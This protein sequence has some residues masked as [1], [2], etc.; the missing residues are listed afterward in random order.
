MIKK[1]EKY[2]SICSELVLSG[3]KDADAIIRSMCI[4]LEVQEVNDDV[5]D[6][7]RED[8]IKDENKS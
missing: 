2:N 5:I 6:A 4:A 8:Y 1:N 3:I 7:I